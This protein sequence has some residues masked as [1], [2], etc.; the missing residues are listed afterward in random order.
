MSAGNVGSA[1]SS[2]VAQPSGKPP[3]V[4]KAAPIAKASPAKPVTTPKKTA[5]PQAKPAKATE[6]K[7]QPP[8]RKTLGPEDKEKVIEH[9]R[10]HPKNR[11]VKRK[12]LESHITSLLGGNVTQKAVRGLVAGLEN[13]KIIKFSENKVDEY[14][15]P[16][17]KK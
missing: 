12:T 13:E 17:R 3:A 16:T 10:L 9:L 15:I 14:T 4:K 5:P 1:T 8:A 6:K 7:P 11:P 2:P